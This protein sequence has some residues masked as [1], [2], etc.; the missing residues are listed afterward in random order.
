MN[1]KEEIIKE[2]YEKGFGTSY[3]TYN[4]AIKPNPSIRLQDAKDYLNSRQDIQVKVKYKNYTIL[5]LLALNLN[6]KLI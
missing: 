4:I 2:A 1:E 5:F 3:E 6:S